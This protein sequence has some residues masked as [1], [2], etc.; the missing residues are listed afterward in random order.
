MA[1]NPQRP[2]GDYKTPDRAAKRGALWI[3]VAIAVAVVVA[4]FAF[5]DFSAT[6]EEAPAATAAEGD[7][8]SPQEEAVIPATD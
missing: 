2:E 1:R 8:E 7:A 3:A 5:D 6:D 4:F